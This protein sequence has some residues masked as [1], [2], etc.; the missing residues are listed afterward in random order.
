ME[1]GPSLLQEGLQL[2]STLSKS[3]GP[4]A[5]RCQILR[6]DSLR[7]GQTIAGRARPHVLPKRN[8]GNLVRSHTG[9]NIR[10]HLRDRLI[11]GLTGGGILQIGHLSKVLADE[12]MH[13]FPVNAGHLQEESSIELTPEAQVPIHGVRRLQLIVDGLRLQ[14]HRRSG[15]RE[16]ARGRGWERG[17]RRCVDAG[18]TRHTGDELPGLAL[19]EV[20]EPYAV[21]KIALQTLA[22]CIVEDTEA[23]AN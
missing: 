22:E 11:I 21:A 6:V 9:K 16:T 1:Y 7:S 2:T 4:I 23:E 17:Q 18:E 15:L 14:I 13:G 10:R 12:G 8:I 3:G 19:N 20:R 5:T